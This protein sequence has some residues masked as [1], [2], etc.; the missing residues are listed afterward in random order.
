MEDKKVYEH[1][2]K[3]D[4]NNSVMDKITLTLGDGKDYE[5]TVIGVFTV[6]TIEDKRFIAVLPEG[7][8]GVLIYDFATEGD[9]FTFNSVAE[10]HAEVVV[11]EFQ[12]IVDSYKQNQ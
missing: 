9:A 6:E 10:E 12:K 4:E 5:C 7:K 3:I 11:A 8:D 2:L 1:E